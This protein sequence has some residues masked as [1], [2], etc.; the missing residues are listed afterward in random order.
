MSRERS[1]SE[2][3]S[4]GFAWLTLLVVIPAV[5]LCCGGPLLFAAIGA[6]LA[7]A[8]AW[9]QGYGGLALLAAAGM[10]LLLWR[11]RRRVGAAQ[12]RR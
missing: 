2:P 1:G 7:A 11:A 4:G 9:V 12:R 6:G 5:A 10:L 3:E 8:V